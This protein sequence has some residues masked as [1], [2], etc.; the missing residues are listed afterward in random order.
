MR[1]LLAALLLLFAQA[2]CAESAV[3]LVRV[4]KSDHKLQLLSGEKLVHEFHVVFGANPKGHKMQEGDERTPEGSYILDYKKSNSAFYR[5]I[6]I[7]YP[8]AKDIASAKSR[9]VK[10]GGEIMIHGQKN[11][12]GWLSSISQR[13]NW[14]N[15][16]VALPNRDMD[17]VWA[18][19]KEGTPI[20]I[21]P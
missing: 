18:L 14:T 2:V 13:F 11:G 6:H 20:E 1:Y 16:C 4:L 3:T 15:G 8:N 9:D 7:S 17:V 12:L 19:V 10:P 5:A 21:L